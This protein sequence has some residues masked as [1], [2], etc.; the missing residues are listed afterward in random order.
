MEF[1][2]A[3]RG[4]AKLR[5]G[6]AGPSGSGK[7]YSALLVASGLAPWE[8]VAV[9]DTESGSADLYDH[10]GPYSVLTIEPPY[11]PQKYID[12]IHAAEQ[13]GFQGVIIDSLSHAWAMEGGLLD[14]HDKATQSKKHNC[15][16]YSA[17][18]DITPKHNALVE[19]ILQAKLHVIATV[20]SKQAYEQV[21]D[22]NGKTK[23][24]KLGLAPVQ[25]EGMEYEF[26]VFLDLSTEHVATSSK[27]RT[28]IFDGQ[29]FTPGKDTGKRL[30]QWLDAGSEA[31]PVPAARPILPEP[32]TPEQ[33]RKIFA[34][35][36]G[37]GW[38]PEQAKQEI[39]KRY[40]VESSKDMS[41]KQ[42]SELIDY[43][44]RLGG[45]G[46]G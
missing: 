42:A 31:P 10:L 12:A 5:M 13:Q 41:K 36:A 22:E 44:V 43:L 40:G 8:M 17:W 30:L 32:I 11:D 7:T 45:G 16:S 21:K 18:R 27:D 37:I 25:R 9:I 2:K 15:N 23:I 26:T 19:A 33:Q 24:V 1:R 14:Q 20:R 29:F 38:T 35:V 34:T 4:K 39:H 46:N 3:K 6:I 28:G